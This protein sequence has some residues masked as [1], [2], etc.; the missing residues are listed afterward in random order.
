M[1]IVPSPYQR[2]LF[3]RL[4]ARAD[5]E[6]RVVYCEAGSPDSPWPEK[7]LAPYE[8]VMPGFYLSW[9][10]S[11]FLLNAGV[12]PVRAADVVVC[13]GYMTL[14]AQRL[15]RRCRGHVPV[16][17][18]GEKMVAAS[19]GLKGA[20]QR[21]LASPLERVDGFVAIGQG[22]KADYERRYPGRPVYSIPY[23]CE[24]ES[25]RKDRPERPR[26]PPVIL[27]CGQMIER[28]GLDI[29]LKAF[30]RV[31]EAGLDARLLLVGREE[32][33]PAMLEEIPEKFHGD[34]ENAGF[35][36]PEALPAFFRRADLFVLPSRYDGWGVVVNQA[37]GAGLPV[38]VSDAVGAG[39]DLVREDRN[40]FVFPS[41][42]ADALAECIDRLLRD[43]GRLAAASDAS[44]ALAPS[45]FP[46]RGAELWADVLHSVAPDKP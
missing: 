34:I 42:D 18:W 2:D 46:E 9:G 6:V 23:F 20:V 11:R 21:R 1:S 14:S 8:S 41:G 45:F 13:N 26:T 28:K 38:I 40:G 32:A 37:V 30:A 39:P 3:A 17:F 19:P 12:P 33:L 4:A 44:W 27:F 15:M 36:A 22:A 5:V 35:Q 29:L 25:F 24:M 43:T 16:L 7:E 31:R 10:G